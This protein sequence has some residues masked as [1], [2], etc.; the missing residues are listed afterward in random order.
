MWIAP[1][2]DWSS[3]DFYNFED[4]NRVENN[5]EVIADFVRYFIAGPPLNTVYNRDMKHIDFADSL[6]RIESNQHLLRQRLTPAGWLP[7]KL[8][9]K[10]NDAFSYIDA[11]RLEHNLNLLY[12]HYRGNVDA[13][14][15]CGAYIVGEGLI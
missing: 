4:L 9:W 3:S 6:N 12:L 1:K 10:A 11:H 5:T 15:I 7:N 2:L 13:V 8:D 14:P